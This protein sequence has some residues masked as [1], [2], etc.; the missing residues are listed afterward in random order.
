M[1]RAKTLPLPSAAVVPPRT[2]L[3]QTRLILAHLLHGNSIAAL[4]RNL[5]SLGRLLDRFLLGSGIDCAE[6]FCSATNDIDAPAGHFTKTVVLYIQRSNP[7]SGANWHTW[8]VDKAPGV[9][10]RIYSPFFCNP[11][12]RAMRT[13]PAILY[14]ALMA[15]TLV[16]SAP[17]AFACNGNGNC[18]NSPGHNKVGAP[19]PI[20]GAG[21]P[22]LAIGYGVYW[23]IKDRKSTRL[24]SSHSDRSRMPSSA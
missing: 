4:G 19:G 3:T 23:L 6:V 14:C 5:E 17:Q 18:E 9:Q 20:A 12:G 15:G 8:R 11:R 22:I 13:L 21:L 7:P 10:C 24:N 16:G 1:S 2:R